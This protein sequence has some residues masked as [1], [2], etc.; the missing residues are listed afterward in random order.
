M[1]D[2]AFWV[3]AE[4]KSRFAQIYRPGKDGKVIPITDPPRDYARTGASSRRS[5]TGRSWTDQPAEVDSCSP[6]DATPSSATV[7][8]ASSMR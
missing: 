8:T 2:T 7:V 5:R 4:K 1:R 3:P 6:N